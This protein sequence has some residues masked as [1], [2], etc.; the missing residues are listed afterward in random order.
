MN[1]DKLPKYMD[2]MMNVEENMEIRMFG[3]FA[4]ISSTIYPLLLL[5]MEEYL[6]FMVDYHLML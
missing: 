2:F 6:Q 1:Q 3:N 5:L 4:L